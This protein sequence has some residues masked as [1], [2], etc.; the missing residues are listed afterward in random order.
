MQCD[1]N[2]EMLQ[3]LSKCQLI[4]VFIRELRVLFK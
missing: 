1:T 3:I 4:I 2:L